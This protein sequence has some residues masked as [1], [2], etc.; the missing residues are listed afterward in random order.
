ILHS[1]QANDVAV[2]EEALPRPASYPRLH[3]GFE[4]PELPVG[5]TAFIAHFIDRI[6]ARDASFAD[7]F[8][9]QD[10][11]LERDYGG[12]HELG[13]HARILLAALQLDDDRSPEMVEIGWRMLLARMNEGGMHLH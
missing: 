12:L 8:A 11:F 2:D 9:A 10:L 3:V 4:Q 13:S 1:Y 7:R 6:R 5:L